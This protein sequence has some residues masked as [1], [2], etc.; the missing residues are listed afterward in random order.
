MSIRRIQCTCFLSILLAVQ[1][2]SLRAV[3][4]KQRVQDA[5]CLASY[6]VHSDL[7]EEFGTLQKNV[8]CGQSPTTPNEA[9][10]AFLCELEVYK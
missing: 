6:L 1:A 5:S 10:T 4:G 7:S 3:L 2:Q 9:E 8:G